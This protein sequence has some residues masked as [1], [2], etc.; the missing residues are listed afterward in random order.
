[1]MRVL[2]QAF[3]N[4]PRHRE[5]APDFR[6]WRL[7]IGVCVLIAAGGRVK[8]GP[9]S[10]LN[11][12]WI[13]ADDHAAYVLGAYG[14][15]RVHTPNLDRLASMGMRFDRAFCNSPLCTASRDSF[16]TGR[17]PRTIGV[18]QVGTP[19]P[20]GE[21][22]LAHELRAAGY[23]TAA[24][25]KMHFNST[26]TYGFDTRV[27]LGLYDLEIEKR[28][29]RPIPQN[30]ECQGPWN[31]FVDPARVWLNAANR[32]YAAV[33][34]DMGATYFVDQ[35]AHFLAEQ[36]R[37][38]FFLMV[39][40]YEPHSPFYFPV[41]DRGRFDPAT[42][43]VPE[44]G[45]EDE[46]QI[47]AVFRELKPDEKQGIAAAYYTSVE[48]LD[49]EVGRLLAALESS[50]HA[51]NTLVIYTA[52]HGYLLGQHGRFEK[53]C[54][55]E[56]AIRAPLLIRCPG[57]KRVGGTTTALVE[58][59]DLFPTVLDLCGVKIPAN[60]QGK[61]LTPLLTGQATRHRTEIF[62]EYAPNDEAA[63][64][65]ERWKLV[66]ERGQRHRA[67]GYDPELPLLGRTIRLYDLQADPAEMHNVAGLPENASRVRHMLGLLADHLQATAREPRLVPKT[68]DPMEILD[69]CVQPRDAVRVYD[70]LLGIVRRHTLA[71]LSAGVV[72]LVL[73]AWLLNAAHR[74]FRSLT[75]SARARP[76]GTSNSKR[77]VL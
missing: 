59:V 9:P 32:P 67:D 57:P 54:S 13:C 12:L 44:V 10:R 33:D 5:G 38:P 53:H 66:F 69:F 50:G 43:P 72:L 70:R 55:Y 51:Q 47:P 6:R 62:V 68:V 17:Y 2:D 61:S 15:H 52:D 73:A 42:F 58:L 65:D 21:R 60:V 26:Q 35:A 39:S 41:E 56:E 8:A 30:V 19:L 63:V 29:K 25:G 27:D 31:P 34:A 49:R 77:V 36:R 46:G 71:S 3:G 37:K 18:T 11:V 28:G 23:D 22:T 14:N 7:W 1:M 24:I 40:L 74:R 16:I 20:A 45:P 76:G 4:N 64:R 48:F 75:Q